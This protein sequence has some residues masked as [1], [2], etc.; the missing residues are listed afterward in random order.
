MSV[1][2]SRDSVAVQ[3]S[4]SKISAVGLA[5][6][7]G[8]SKSKATQPSSISGISVGALDELKSIGVADESFCGIAACD[9]GC[10]G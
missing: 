9:R 1:S 6:M 5:G 4:K 2:A 10:G 7:P 8:R 3:K